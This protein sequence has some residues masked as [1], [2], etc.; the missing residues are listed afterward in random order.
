MPWWRNKAS[1]L[2][3][4][5]AERLERFHGR[6]ASARRE[7]GVQVFSTGFHIWQTRFACSLLE[8]R[9]RVRAQDLGPL[10]AVVACGIAAG[11]DMAE[12][13]GRA[14][15]GGGYQHRDFACEPA[16]A[17]RR[18]RRPVCGWYATACRTARTR[19]GAGSA[20]HSGSCGLPASCR[21]ARAAAVRRSATWAVMW[22]STS[23]SQQ[24]FSMNWLG[25]STASHSTPLMPDTW[26]SSTWVSMW[27]RPWPNSWNRVV[28]SSWVSRALWRTPSCMTP[29]AKLHTRW[30]TG[31]CSWWVSGRSQ[32]PR[33]SSIQAPPRLPSR[34]VVS[35]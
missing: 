9:I 28:T 20:C 7:Y 22:R 33:T 6:A 27:C 35:R 31:V 24:K 14:A 17:G 16:T 2:W 32:R 21:T 30:A 5:A 25:N 34:A 15:P 13:V 19:S 12:S 18:C 29:S 4:A 3:L 23:H 11:K 26:R 1:S 10:V 8:G